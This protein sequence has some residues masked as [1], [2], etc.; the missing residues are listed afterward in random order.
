M[1]FHKLNWMPD[2][3]NTKAWLP[4]DLHPPGLPRAPGAYLQVDPSPSAF[5]AGSEPKSLG[6]EPLQVSSC[7]NGPG[8]T[9][10]SCLAT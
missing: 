8:S 10:A 7:W 2:T 6:G 9:T 3:G 1:I 4:H 5:S